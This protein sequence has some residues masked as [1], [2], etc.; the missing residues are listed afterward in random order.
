MQLSRS[1]VRTWP[2]LLAAFMVASLACTSEAVEPETSVSWAPA[3]D[4]WQ[5]GI[6]IAALPAGFALV[7]NL[8]NEVS[9][10]HRFE[11]GEGRQLEV[12][13]LLDPER[14]PVEG[15]PLETWNGT[16]YYQ[17]SGEV[18]TQIF[19][20]TQGVRLGATSSDLTVEELVAI[21]KSITYDPGADEPSG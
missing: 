10:A 14:F 7:T 20:E 5:S 1:P 18:R 19:F 8:G 6:A 4:G 9:V 11:D 16:T 15:D 13:R 3:D 12:F 2:S 17:A 21:A